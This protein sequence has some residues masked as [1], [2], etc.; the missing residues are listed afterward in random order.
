MIE[1]E[2]A[3]DVVTNVLRFI[4]DDVYVYEYRQFW[5]RIQHLLHRSV[6]GIVEEVQVQVT[7]RCKHQISPSSADV[8]QCMPL[9]GCVVIVIRPIDKE[10]E[11]FEENVVRES[12]DCDLLV[13][14][15]HTTQYQ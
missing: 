5:P 7:W 4:V 6:G 8:Y 10:F 14:F 9:P 3:K 11:Y 15:A 1:P 2:C 13:K 12:S